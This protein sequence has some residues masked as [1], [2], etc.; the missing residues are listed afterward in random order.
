MLRHWSY[1]FLALNLVQERHNSI[2]NA[3]ELS[4]SCTNRSIYP[5]YEFHGPI[6][7]HPTLTY[8]LCSYWE[9]AGLCT[10]ADHIVGI[11]LY[12]VHLPGQETSQINLQRGG[13]HRNDTECIRCATLAILDLIS[14]KWSIV[15]SGWKSLEEK[16]S[17][18]YTSYE[19]VKLLADA[20]IINIVSPNKIFWFWQKS[21]K[22][23][24]HW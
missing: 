15:E 2:A 23:N 20:W 18:D 17:V 21:R 24:L 13:V 19:I 4:L 7:Q 10:L 14:A 3:I 6:S 8:R 1:I 5:W 22:R 11:D 12:L 16:H 9:S